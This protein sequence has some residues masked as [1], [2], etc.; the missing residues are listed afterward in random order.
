MTTNLPIDKVTP[1]PRVIAEKSAGP[2]KRDL[3][4]AETRKRILEAALKHFSA[5]GFE[6]SS[7][8]DISAEAGV[9]HAL[10]RLHFGTKEGLWKEAISFL[11]EHQSDLMDAFDQPADQLT[12]E[13][14]QRMLRQYVSYCAKHPDYMR[15]MLHETMKDSERLEWIVK[16]HTYDVHQ[17]VKKLFE[18]AMDRGIIVRAP[19]ETIIYI[20]ISSSQMIFALRSEVQKIYEV[21]VLENEFVEDHAKTLANLLMCKR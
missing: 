13:S 10:I 7:V 5:R 3:Q 18:T 1:K 15:I 6:S 19:I 17:R 20:F 8:R 9:T 2:T 11:F 12:P 21:D 16:H 4:G 14:F